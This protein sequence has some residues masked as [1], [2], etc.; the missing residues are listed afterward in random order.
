MIKGHKVVV[1]MPA[2][3][4]VQT[5]RRTYDEAGAQGVVD[6]FVVVDDASADETLARA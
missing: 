3:N 4:A 6:A 1:V 5:L 2:Y